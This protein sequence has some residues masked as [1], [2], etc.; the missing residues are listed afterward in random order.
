MLIHGVSKN[1]TQRSDWT[2]TTKIHCEIIVC[3]CVCSVAQLGGLFILCDETFRILPHSKF[4]MYSEV[5]LIMV[6]FLYNTSLGV[7]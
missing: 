2:T 1:Q 7:I 4:N 6:I 3:M 5:L